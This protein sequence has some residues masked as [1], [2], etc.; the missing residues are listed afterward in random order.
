M[1]T[2]ATAVAVVTVSYN[3]EDVITGFLESARGGSS[4]MV[5]ADNPSPQSERT[6]SHAKAAG[7]IVVRM[8]DNVGYGGAINAAIQSLS[9]EIDAILISNPDVRIGA[10]AIARMLE[11]LRSADDIGA[12]G[13]KILNDDGTVFPSARQIPSLR[14][15]VGHALF[16]RVW[17]S[18]PWSRRYR[19]EGIDPDVR[20]DVG[21]LSGAC[22]LV[23][24]EAFE[25]I[26]GFDESYFMYFEDVD[27]G[28]RLS[29]S[30]W[31]NVFEPAAQVTHIGGTSTASARP[32][33]LVTHHRSAYRFLASKYPGPL[34]APLRWALH[35]GLV[36]R[37][38][39][40]TRGMRRQSSS[41]D[42]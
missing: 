10:G 15:G 5:V 16:F 9:P 26:G 35:A 36:V 29:K 27:L 8:P 14:T 41:E 12:V 19:Q 34:L 17:P 30:G 18:N 6:I 2:K 4:L 11:T 23:E 40:L 20:R 37:A 38:G 21:W 1:G 22:L 33:M 24:R 39:W 13:P 7:A 3:S 31:R 42:R 25:Q 28:H 32:Q